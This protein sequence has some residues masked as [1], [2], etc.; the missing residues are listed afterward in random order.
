MVYVDWKKDQLLSKKE[1][2]QKH[3]QDQLKTSL[4]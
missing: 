1:Q 4:N 2:R 3:S